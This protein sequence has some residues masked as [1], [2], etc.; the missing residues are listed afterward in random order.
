MSKAPNMLNLDDFVTEKFIMLYGKERRV[1]A[2]TVSQFI[3]VS[4]LEETIEEEDSASQMKLLIDRI[5]EFL[6]DTTEEDL[7]KMEID[8]L[9]ALLAFIRG[10]N[11]LEAVKAAHGAATEAEEAEGA[12]GNVVASKVQ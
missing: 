10:E 9:M 2:M 11:P 4:K 5:L 1:K 7:Q 12:E 3:S 8:Q 6:D